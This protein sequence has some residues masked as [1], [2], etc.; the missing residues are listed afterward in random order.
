M[1]I[2]FSVSFFTFYFSF[3]LLKEYKTDCVLFFIIKSFFSFGGKRVRGRSGRGDREGDCGRAERKK[4]YFS[5]RRT[6]PQKRDRKR[7]CKQ[8]NE[9]K[10]LRRTRTN[11]YLCADSWRLRWKS[12]E[13]NVF[14]LLARAMGG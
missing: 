14:D 6:G 7:E 3:Y 2:P 12:V 11:R 13:W 4:N 10:R 9:K 1:Q 8:K 5:T